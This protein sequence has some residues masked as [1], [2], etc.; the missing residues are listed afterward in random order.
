MCYYQHK[1]FQISGDK[2]SMEKFGINFKQHS[3]SFP[4]K[5]H[6]KSLY[7]LH[8]DIKIQLYFYIVILKYIDILLSLYQSI[9]I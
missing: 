9:L 5:S 3:K 7:N 8:L 6:L 4:K 1:T 2:R